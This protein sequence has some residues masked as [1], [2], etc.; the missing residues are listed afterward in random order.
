MEVG[1]GFFAKYMDG[2]LR[3]RGHAMK[4]LERGDLPTLIQ[5]HDAL[6]KS[7]T[8]RGSAW[9]DVEAAT[10]AVEIKPVRMESLLDACGIDNGDFER[11]K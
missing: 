9:A 1:D 8:K 11:G 2:V 7:T 6:L 10:T 5:S 4:N 3:Q